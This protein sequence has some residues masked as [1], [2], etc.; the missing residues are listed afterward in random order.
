MSRTL[1]IL[2]EYLCLKGKVLIMLCLFNLLITLWNYTPLHMSLLPIK[3]ACCLLR[4]ETKGLKS[5][6]CKHNIYPNIYRT[7]LICS[8][9]TNKQ[10][11]KVEFN[12]EST[13][14]ECP[15]LYSLHGYSMDNILVSW[16]LSVQPPHVCTRRAAVY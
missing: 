5:Q 10:L 11:L 6:A 2:Y 9:R 3:C 8:Y 15:V 14:N 16:E 7:Y 12:K 1:L 13:W 4:P